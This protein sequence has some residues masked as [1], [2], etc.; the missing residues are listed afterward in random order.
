MR[1]FE[2]FRTESA[3]FLDPFHSAGPQGYRV[4]REQAS[5]FAKEVADDFNPIHDVDAKR[6]CVPG[7][8]LFA[9]VL[10]HYGLSQSMH[11]DFRGMVGADVALHF[12]DTT[13]STLEIADGNGKVYLAVTREGDVTR[14]P[15]VIEAVV[16]RYVAFSG[17]NFPHV[18]QPLLAERGVMF[19]PDRPL[20]IYDNMGFE[21]DRLPERPERVDMAADGAA[22]EIDGK[23]GDTTL[24]FRFDDDDE[25]V[26]RGTKTLVV[27]GLRPYDEVAMQACIDTINE[28]RA[29]YHG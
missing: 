20:V 22:L 17:H 19:N 12:P 26:G 14:D 23:R 11:F 25:T 3:M 15:D 4:S 28:R 27:S 18:L 8:L 16:R 10:T 1:A 13:D 21:F 6:F 29:A 5:R 7:D 24:A 9:L 2:V